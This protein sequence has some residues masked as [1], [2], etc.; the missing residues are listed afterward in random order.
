M[1]HALFT[2]LWQAALLLV[3]CIAGVK[4]MFSQWG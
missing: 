4:W 1:E 2:L 3:G